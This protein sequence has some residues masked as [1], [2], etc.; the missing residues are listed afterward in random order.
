VFCPALIEPA[1]RP[2]SFWICN[3]N[4]YT[5]LCNLLCLYNGKQWRNSIVSGKN[6][7]KAP[8]ICLKMCKMS[9]AVGTGRATVTF[10]H[11]SLSACKRIHV[12]SLFELIINWSSIKR[13]SNQSINKSTDRSINQ[14]LSQWGSLTF[15]QS[16]IQNVSIEWSEANVWIK[17]QTFRKILLRQYISPKRILDVGTV[18]HVEHNLNFHRH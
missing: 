8:W 11:S 17:T 9:L 4:C 14:F 12:S 1:P 7:T 18:I 3:S 6:F 16:V 2:F 10:A 15:R 5:A 13:P